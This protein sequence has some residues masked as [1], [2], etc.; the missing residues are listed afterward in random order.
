MD[1]QRSEHMEKLSWRMTALNRCT[2]TESLWKRK[3]VCRSSLVLTEI[4]HPSSRRK[5][6][7]D[8]IIS[9]SVSTAIGWNEN[10]AGMSAYLASFLVAAA[11][12]ADAA[13]AEEA[14]R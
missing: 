7:A 13:S 14:G 11:L 8:S 6:T 2:V 9:P 10:E 1:G 3:A 5:S 4:L 12:A